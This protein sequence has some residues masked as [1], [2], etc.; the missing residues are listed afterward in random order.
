MLLAQCVGVYV[1]YKIVSSLLYVL[2]DFW[3][4]VFGVKMYSAASFMLIRVR[5]AV[6]GRFVA[7]IE[8]DC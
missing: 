5:G 4:M 6:S 8:D 7:C 3:G 1:G 2:A